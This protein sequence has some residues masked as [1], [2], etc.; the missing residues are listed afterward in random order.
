MFFFFKKLKQ[1][2]AEAG[3][4]RVIAG[5]SQCSIKLPK[6]RDR[7]TTAPKTDRPFSVNLQ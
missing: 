3:D 7:Q 4:Q 5:G 6:N 1:Q 2:R